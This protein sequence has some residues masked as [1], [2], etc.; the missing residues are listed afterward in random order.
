MG[1]F[2]IKKIEIQ[3]LDHE[4]IPSNIRLGF[5]KK[6][7]KLKK[8]KKGF[9]SIIYH[10][11][12]K[13]GKSL[14]IELVPSCHHPIPIPAAFAKA[15]PPFWM[16]SI[17][18]KAAKKQGGHF[19]LFLVGPFTIFIVVGVVLALPQNFPIGLMMIF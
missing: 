19:Y 16:S 10:T 14:A 15:T 1:Q 4:P 7:R 2:F 12:D 8:R 9:K 13:M 17:L 6:S 11:I 3:I 5:I 18:T